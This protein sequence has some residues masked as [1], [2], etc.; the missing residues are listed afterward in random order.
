MFDGP[1]SLKTSSFTRFVVSPAISLQGNEHKEFSKEKLDF[2]SAFDWQLVF[3]VAR[4]YVR[5]GSGPWASSSSVCDASVS[6]CVPPYSR[7][8][9][10]VVAYA[11]AAALGHFYN[12]KHDIF[13]S[14][15]LQTD[16]SAML[17]IRTCEMQDVCT[18]KCIKVGGTRTELNIYQREL[19]LEV[20]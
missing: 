2:R 15:P 7:C 1:S 8:F 4:M 11:F 19:P 6:S 3:T 5:L 13:Q 12:P 9:S 18:E 20:K 10:A 17:C 16:H 14:R